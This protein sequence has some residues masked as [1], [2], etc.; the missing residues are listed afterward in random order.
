MTTQT[1]MSMR[2]VCEAG[3]PQRLW[4]QLKE[5]Y[6]NDASVEF[7]GHSWAVMGFKTVS[8]DAFNTEVATVKQV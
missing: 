2:Q 7:D 6:K 1:L 4:Q 5:A 3:T 8:D